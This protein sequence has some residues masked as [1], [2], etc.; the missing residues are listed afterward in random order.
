MG[1]SSLSTTSSPPPLPPWAPCTRSTMKCSS[2]STLPT[3][4]SPSMA[5]S[6]RF[7]C[8]CQL[9]VQLNSFE[10]IWSR[11]KARSNQKLVKMGIHHS[12]FFLFLAILFWREVELK[13]L[14][15]VIAENCSSLTPKKSKKARKCD[16]ILLYYWVHSYKFD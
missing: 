2:S 16:K 13:K 5:T 8:F 9:L 7:L 3:L 4:T 6:R 11:L 10:P 14:K 1:S 12:T 15:S